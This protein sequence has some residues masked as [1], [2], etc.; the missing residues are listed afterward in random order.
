MPKICRL[1]TPIKEKDLEK[2]KV[3][4]KI[5]LSGVIFTARDTAHKLLKKQI[6]KGKKPPFDLKGSVIYYAGPTPP[7]P[8]SIIGSIGPTT[9]YRMDKYAPFFYSLGVK[10]T[11]G[12]GSRSEEV[13]LA[14]KK[15]KAVYFSAVGG[16]AALL[17]K[18]VKKAEI[19]AYQ[20]LG[21]EAIRKLWVEDFPCI[22]A[23]DIYGDDIYKKFQKPF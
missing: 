14:L 11:I 16:V 4:D 23:N 19:I 1:K 17:A 21:T 18:H 10:A 9:S 20:E 6:E 3:G 15:Y 12:K 8:D 13:I 7:K 22:V 2:L 5:L